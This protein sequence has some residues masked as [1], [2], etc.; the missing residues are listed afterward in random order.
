MIKDGHWLVN[1]PKYF[2]FKAEYESILEIETESK[3]SRYERILKLN[4][5]LNDFIAPLI[6]ERSR[7]S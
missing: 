6:E 5:F 1:S 7:F 2:F 4:Q 3:D